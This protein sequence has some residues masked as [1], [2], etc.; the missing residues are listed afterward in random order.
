MDKFMVGRQPIFD[1]KLSVRGYELLFRCPTSLK[2]S[3][4]VM[5]AD[6]LVHSGLDIGLQSLVSN[7]LAFV[8]ATSSFLAGEQEVPFS[9]RQAVIEVLKDVPR[10]PDVLAGCRRLV[11]NGY[12]LALDDYVWGNDDDPFLDLVSIVKLDL[13]TLTPA[14]LEESVKRCSARRCPARGREG[15]DPRAAAGL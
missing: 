8:N 13:L 10:D 5:T 4:D 6:V 12:T 11:K 2:P 9:P 14:Q 15:R 3:G 7:K 1:A